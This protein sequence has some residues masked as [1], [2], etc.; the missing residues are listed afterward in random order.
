MASNQDQLNLGLPAIPDPPELTDEAVRYGNAYIGVS[1]KVAAPT[2]W[3]DYLRR[4]PVRLTGLVVAA[5]THTTS[6]PGAVIAVQATA[7]AVTGIMAI[8]VTG[9]PGSGEA[10]VVYNPDGTA[11]L[12][13]NG[14]D[15]VTAIAI[16]QLRVPAA[17]IAFLDA[18]TDPA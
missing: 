6:S 17:V 14:G 11:T 2:D 16:Q 5:D 18:T 12:D 4:I 7:G 9:S 8:R 1:G 15:A 3:G 13:F 10:R